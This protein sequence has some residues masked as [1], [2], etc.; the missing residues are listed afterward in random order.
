MELHNEVT[1]Y[2]IGLAEFSF[3]VRLELGFRVTFIGL[4]IELASC[5]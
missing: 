5:W 3:Q 2:N 4:G 1:I